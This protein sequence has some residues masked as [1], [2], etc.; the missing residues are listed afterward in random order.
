MHN[1]LREKDN[2]GKRQKGRATVES[3]R[4]FAITGQDRGNNAAGVADSL[5]QF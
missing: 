2:N 1:I 5:G 3:E 4:S